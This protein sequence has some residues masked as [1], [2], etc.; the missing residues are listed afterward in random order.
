MSLCCYRARALQ[1][2]KKAVPSITVLA[3]KPESRFGDDILALYPKLLAIALART[4]SRSV[5]E[6]LIQSTSVRTLQKRSQFHGG[7]LDAWLVTILRN[8]H[9]DETRSA[10]NK[11]RDH[12][13]PSME[14]LVAPGNPEV[15]T[16]ASE[17]VEALAK[18]GGRCRELLLLYAQGYKV[19]EIAEWLSIPLGTALRSMGECRGQLTDFL[20]KT[21]A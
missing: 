18:L 17:V 9:L 19:R 4:G 14:D 20:N 15:Q 7:S 16:L 3:T 10:W 2:D 8:I 5:A 6:D 13:E 1:A 12:D 21:R 11:Y